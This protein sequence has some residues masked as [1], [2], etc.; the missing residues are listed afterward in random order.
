MKGRSADIKEA[1]MG[2]P[3]SQRTPKSAYM[4]KLKLDN[5]DLAPK[6]E[7][8]GDDSQRRLDRLEQKLERIDELLSEL[9]EMK[10]DRKE[11]D[12]PKGLEKK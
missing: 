7:D 9:R 2:M 1:P 3:G 11:K 5:K 8:R 4:A 6:A 10:K 12:T